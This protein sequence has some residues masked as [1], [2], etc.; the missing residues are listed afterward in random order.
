M[1]VSNIRLYITVFLGVFLTIFIIAVTSEVSVP[2][3]LRRAFLG[4]GGFTVLFMVLGQIIARYIFFD[5]HEQPAAA[6]SNVPPGFNL[7]VSAAEPVLYPETNTGSGSGRSA[8]PVVESNA[9]TTGF[10][11][12]SARQIDPQVSRIIN[13]DPGKAAEIIRKMG[14]E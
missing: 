14:L 7:D 9:H 12:L 4:A 1:A 5:P 2:A 8:Q 3:G 6:D 10:V 13:D 11:P